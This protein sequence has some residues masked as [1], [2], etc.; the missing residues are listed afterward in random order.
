MEQDRFCFSFTVPEQ[1]QSMRLD[2][3]LSLPLTELGLRGRRRLWQWRRI[4]VN[5]KPRQPGFI[6]GQGDVIRLEPLPSLAAHGTEEGGA[7]CGLTDAVRPLEPVSFLSGNGPRLVALVGDFLALHKPCGLHSAHI[8]GG[9]GFSLERL[10]AQEW[11][12]LCERLSLGSRPLPLLLTRLDEVTSGIVLAAASPEAAAVFRAAEQ[13]GEVEKHYLA[14][15]RGHLQETLLL[16]NTLLTAKRKLTLALD[17]DNPDPARHSLVQPLGEVDA[18]APGQ[19]AG[20]L[21]RVLI[22]RGAR[23][24]IRAHLA[25]AGYPLLGEWLYPVPLEKP[26]GARL[27]LHHAALA[28]PGFCAVDMPDWGLGEEKATFPGAIPPEQPAL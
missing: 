12:A 11:A 15:V 6:V 23:H 5:G 1:G 4:T 27:Y 17:E 8:A 10:L 24:Q 19:E 3:A 2:V 7:G 18:A 25:R 21:V 28:F 16:K 13:R 22:K 26:A 20:T 14:V 9:A